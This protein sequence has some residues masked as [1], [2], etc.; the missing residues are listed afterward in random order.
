LKEKEGYKEVKE[1]ECQT[2]YDNS[3]MKKIV[4]M[5]KENKKIDVIITH[6]TCAIAPILQFHTTSMMNYITAHSL[7]C[8]YPHWTCEDKGFMNPCLYMEGKMNLNAVD[9]LMKYV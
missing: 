5:K 8:L 7:V 6:W 2:V 4:K 3:T 1:M 9:S